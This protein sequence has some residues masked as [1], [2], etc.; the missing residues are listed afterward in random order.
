[1]PRCWLERRLLL[2][3]PARLA[4]NREDQVALRHDAGE[5]PQAGH[6]RELDG[7]SPR[8]RDDARAPVQVPFALHPWMCSLRHRKRTRCAVNFSMGLTLRNFRAY[9]PARPLVT[10]CTNYQ[11]REFLVV[12]VACCTRRECFAVERYMSVTVNDAF[13][14]KNQDSTALWVHSLRAALASLPATLCRPPS[15]A[16]RSERRRCV[17]QCSPGKILRPRRERKRGPQVWP[18]R[19]F[20]RILCEYKCR[21]KGICVDITLS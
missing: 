2:G 15:G 21:C 6:R 19:R 4:K 14:T 11:I 1:M 7:D 16:A 5:L 12:F 17:Q 9:T 10:T 3:A 20:L 8:G 18:C 13:G